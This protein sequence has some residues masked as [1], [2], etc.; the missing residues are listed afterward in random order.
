[1]VIDRLSTY[2]VPEEL[3]RNQVEGFLSQ[4]L[5]G[6]AKDISFKID[7]ILNLLESEELIQ[8]IDQEKITIAMVKPDLINGVNQPYGS[9]SDAELDAQIRSDI[10]D[11]LEE[12]FSISLSLTPEMVEEWYGGGPK[13]RQLQSPPI[14]ENRYGV[15]HLTRWD[16]YKALMTSGP[17]TISLLFSN[18]GSAVVEWRRQMGNHWDIRRVREEFPNSLRA[19]YARDPHNNLLHGSDS[20]ESVK[21]EV[22]LLKDFLKQY[23]LLVSEH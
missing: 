21:H 20:A 22:K 19:K 12:I 18:T 13:E 16:E 6:L 1:M 23:R 15:K 7:S 11:P 14:D 8:L 2:Q 9:L 5:L 3:T 10:A 17:V 4:A